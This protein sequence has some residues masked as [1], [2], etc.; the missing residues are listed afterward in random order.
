[1]DHT[2]PAGAGDTLQDFG[3]VPAGWVWGTATAAHQIEGGNVGN[4]WWDWEHTPGSGTRESSGDACD[5]WHRWFEDLEL[6]KAIGLDAYRFS[7]EWS[8]IEPAEG[9]F[10]I[11]A[12]EHYRAILLAAHELGLRASVTLHHFTTPRWM[13]AQGGWSN[14]LVVER[15]QRF[16]DIAA[17]HLGDQIDMAATLNEPNVVAH[18]GYIGGQFPPGRPHDWEGFRQASRHLLL[19]HLAAREALRAGP[20]DFPVG[21]TLALPD[22]VLHADGDLTS[23]GERVTDLRPD[24]PRGEL[25]WLTA[26][27]YLDAA[28]DDDYIG[29]QTYFTEHVG[30]DGAELPL[31]SGERVTQMGWPFTPEALGASVRVAA[32]VARVPV[33]VTENGVAAAEDAERIEYYSRSLRSLRAA[34]DDGVDVRGFFA[35]SLLDNFEWA[36]GFEPTFGLVEVDPVSF[37]RSSKPSAAWLGGLARASRGAHV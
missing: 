30:P 17:Q 3:P 4:D 6:V 22:T 35:W 5:S 20:G 9:E 13:A 26:G 2:E 12:L 8:R 24:G 23:P 10:S 11:A 34:M 1:M 32:E 37:A 7:L 27:Q 18:A 19:G 21:L 31:P 25:G 28:R 36:L 16:A 15:F 29:V 33:I 14:P